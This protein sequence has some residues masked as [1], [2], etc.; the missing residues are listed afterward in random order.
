MFDLLYNFEVQIDGVLQTESLWY[1]NY[2]TP[3]PSAY[4]AMCGIQR[5]VKKYYVI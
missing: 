2:L 4:L 5:E 1:V 3:I